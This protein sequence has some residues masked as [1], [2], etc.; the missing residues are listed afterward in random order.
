MKR[1]FGVY[2]KKNE[3]QIA[4]QIV[5]AYVV[6]AGL[7]FLFSDQMLAELSD[8]PERFTLLHLLNDWL[9]VLLTAVLLGWLVRRQVGVLR[10]KDER[11]R[12]IAQG[13][14]VAAGGFF[15]IR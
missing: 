13:V 1:F 12:E 11:L 2:L 8:E 7:W 6:V 10:R 5:T 15:S 9:Y 3:R 4:I 14:S